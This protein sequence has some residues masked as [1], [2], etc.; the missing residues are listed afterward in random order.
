MHCTRKITDSIYW[1]GGSD[2]RLAL[3]ENLFPIPRGVSYNSYLILDEKTAVIDTV[4]SSITRQFL[5]NIMHVLNG[6][7]LDYLVVNHMEPD[8]CANIEELMLRFPDMKIV[9]NA[10]TFS[11]IGQFYDLDLEGRTVAVKEKDSLCLGQHTLCFYFTPMV[12]WP[13][14]MMTYEEHE[15]L[16]FS[17]DAFGSFGALDGCLFNDEVDFEHDWISDAR[18]YYCN[19]VGKYGTQVQAALKKLAGADIKMICPLHGPVWRSDLGYFLDKYDH[20]SRYEPEE[21]A[22]VILY[23][24]MYGDTENAANILASGLSEAGMKKIAVYD[25]SNTHVSTLIS[26]VFRCSHLVLASPTYNNG[27]YPAM[28]DF[29]HD[30]KALNLQNRTVGLIENGSWAPSSAKQMKV[31]L[32]EM[33][34]MQILEPVVTIK[35]TLKEDSL[36]SLSLLKESLLSSCKE[37]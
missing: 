34:G 33:K 28:L 5:D 1:I 27:I 30:M 8:H 12:H 3:F 31:L 2:R 37:K 13:E 14:V 21:E 22:V 17:A 25:V 36:N 35:S 20:W 7:K 16:L 9:G 10:K 24:S 26:E 19:I 23:G 6:R 15:K 32:E 4:D 11:I 29:L 18:R